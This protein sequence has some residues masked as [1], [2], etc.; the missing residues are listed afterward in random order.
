MST[1]DELRRREE[2]RRRADEPSPRGDAPSLTEP[3]IAEDDD[4]R[5]PLGDRLVK[6]LREKLAEA[7]HPSAEA[8]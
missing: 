6:L 4:Q 3:G 1:F 8:E 2:L 7:T 5:E